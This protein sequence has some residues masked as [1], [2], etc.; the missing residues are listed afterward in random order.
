MCLIGDFCRRI[1]KEILKKTN[2]YFQIYIIK[3]ILT[4]MNNTGIYFPK[5]L[6]LNGTCGELKLSYI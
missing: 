4:T 1:G 5:L 3:R 6:L 2:Y